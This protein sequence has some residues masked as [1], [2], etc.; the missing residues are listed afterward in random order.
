ML[1]L[2]RV[3]LNSHIRNLLK[4][5]EY[6]A[7]HVLEN[8]KTQWKQKVHHRNYKLVSYVGWITLGPIVASTLFK[9]TIYILDPR[10]NLGLRSISFLFF[11]W[12]RTY[13]AWILQKCHCTRIQTSRENAFLRIRC[14][15]YNIFLRFWAHSQGLKEYLLTTHPNV[16]VLIIECH[17]HSPYVKNSKKEHLHS[18]RLW[19][20][21]KLKLKAVIHTP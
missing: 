4:D 18:P 17:L 20:H 8:N 2:D 3:N 19:N 16:L 21:L 12:P 6:Q 1:K 11:F 7:M 13:L 14:G 10:G 9:L 5:L 15:C